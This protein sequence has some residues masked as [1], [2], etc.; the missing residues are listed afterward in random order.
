MTLETF[1][2]KFDL[3]ADAPDAMAKMRELILQL[4]AHGELVE[5][6]SD[7]EPASEL[8]D[9]IEKH[10]A[11]LRTRKEFRGSP[12]EPIDRVELAVIPPSWEWVRLG[13]VVDYGSPHKAESVDIPEDAWLLDLE[14][15]EKDTSRLLKRKSFRDSPSKSTK[16][17]FAVGDVL[18]G[19]L[20][21]YLNKVIVADAPGYC[22][23]EIIPIRT[24]GFIY[25]EYLCHALK[26]PGFIAYAN[27]KSYGMNLPRLG[28]EDA[29]RAPFPVPP[30]AEQKR[31]VAKVDELM[32]LCDRLENQQQEREARHATL[33]RASL[34]RFVEAP[35]PANL[36]FL[37]HRSYNITPADLRKSILALAVQGKLVAQDPND[38]PAAKILARL[39]KRKADVIAAKQTRQGKVSRPQSAPDAP[40]DLP[41]SWAWV[42]VDTVFYKVTDGTHFTPRYVDSGIRFVSAKDIVDGELIFDRCKFITRDEHEELYRRCNPEH[43]DIVVTKSGSIGSVALVKDRG[44]FSLFE[45]LALLKFDLRELCPEFLVYV[46]RHTCEALTAEYIRGMAVKHLHLDILRGIEFALPPLAE[47]R[48]IVAK[49]DELMTLVDALAADLGTARTIGERL[50]AAAVAE[51]TQAA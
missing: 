19:K 18:Y 27:S 29:R 9:R 15:I 43:H 32:A 13:N 47:Q 12:V 6:S 49:V 37:F 28:T 4:A 17:A 34:A 39:A 44:E 23:T 40:T 14:D 5:Q 36:D 38:E 48:R 22:T 3:F 24:F 25:P 46:L 31:I 33:V 1:F 2:E 7:D 30:L 11:T 51:L 10:I 26:R 50:L 35:T 41:Q 20:R 21:P 16:T 45:S 42:N 8:V